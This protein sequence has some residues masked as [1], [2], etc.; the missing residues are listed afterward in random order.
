MIRP[1]GLAGFWKRKHFPHYQVNVGGL[2]RLLD[3]SPE[4]RD[5]IGANGGVVRLGAV[6]NWCQQSME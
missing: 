2:V 5:R 6:Q 3:D 1:S 4:E